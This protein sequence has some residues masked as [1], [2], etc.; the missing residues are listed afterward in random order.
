MTHSSAI[1]SN[2]TLFVVC[3]DLGVAARR[4]RRA[5]FR[6]ADIEP[7]PG[8]NPFKAIAFPLFGRLTA[9]STSC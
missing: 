8:R 3:D 4:D 6:V 9:L 2:G 5:R 7:E 1:R